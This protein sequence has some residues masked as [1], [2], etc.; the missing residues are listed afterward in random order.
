MGRQQHCDSIQPSKR[1]FS[2]AELFQEGEEIDGRIRREGWRDERS[3]SF[4][5]RSCLN[6]PAQPRTLWYGIR[7][8]TL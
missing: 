2:G 1:A 4:F 7:H 8:E 5:A 6:V 3:N